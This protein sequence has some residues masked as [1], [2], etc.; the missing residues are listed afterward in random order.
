[1]VKYIN[2]VDIE[3]SSKYCLWNC[4]CCCPSFFSNSIFCYI[5]LQTDAVKTVKVCYKDNAQIVFITHLKLLV[6]LEFYCTTKIC[7]CK[8]VAKEHDSTS[9][10]RVNS[11][12]CTW[13]R[14]ILVI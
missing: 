2:I 8:N 10:K 7:I 3:S 13:L 14:V 12:I 9:N 4:I 6:V 11:I 1:M 5:E